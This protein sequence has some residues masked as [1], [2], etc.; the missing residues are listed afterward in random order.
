M[1]PRIKLVTLNIE[2]SR[3]LDTV[4]PFLQAQG[5]DVI[6]LQ[7][8]VSADMPAF[9]R[10]LGMS[11]IYGY[12]AYEPQA[13]TKEHPLPIVSVG[14]YTRLVF[15]DVRRDYIW[16]GGEEMPEKKRFTPDS[17]SKLL[18]SAL[19]EKGGQT[20]RIGTTHFTWTADGKEN[21]EQLRDLQTLLQHL[22]R[23]P[24][25]VFCGDFNAPRGGAVFDAIAAKYRDNVPPKYESSL[26]PV[27][28]RAPG[29]KLMVDG[30]FS[31]THYG[32]SNVEMKCG[33]S[34]HCALVADVARVG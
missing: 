1:R 13:A 5:A 11:G 10:A 29:L 27:L 7:E 15:S 32:V 18:L 28:H 22:S 8:L 23:F 33:I 9:E 21:P 30:L 26:D 2:L 16:G 24:G 4:I 20:F 3:R 19:F 14:I 34:D 6:C 31:T 25:I 17:S 12:M